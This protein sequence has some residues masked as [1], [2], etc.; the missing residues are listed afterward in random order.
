MTFMEPPAG[1]KR[2]DG[3]RCRYLRSSAVVMRN[4]VAAT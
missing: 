3:S 2:A 4:T 1:F